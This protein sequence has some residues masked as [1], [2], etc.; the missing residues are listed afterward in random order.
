MSIKRKWLAHISSIL[1]TAYYLINAEQADEKVRLVRSVITVEHLRNSWNKTQT[2]PLL[3]LTTWLL[4]PR[5]MRYAPRE[6]RIPRP[7][8]SKYTE[9]VLG[10]LYYDGPISALK[11]QTKLILNIP[12]GGFVAMNPRTHDDSLMS[13]AAR[14]GMPVLSLDYRKAPEHPYPY[15]LHECFDVYRQLVLSRGRCAGLFT[16]EALQIIISG[17]SAGGNLAAGVTLMVLETTVPRRG[18]PR[19]PPP[20]DMLCEQLPS[21]VGLVLIYPCLDVNIGNWMTDEQM[22]LIKDRNAGHINRRVLRRKN[23]VYLR[24]ANT[25]YASDSESTPPDSTPSQSRTSSLEDLPKPQFTILRRPSSSVDTIARNG[26]RHFETPIAVPSMLSYFSD[27]VLTPEMMRAMIILYIGNRRKPDFSTDYYLSPV[28]APDEL[29]A[30]FPRTCFLT[31]ER[32]PLVDDTCV[33]AGRLRRAKRVEPGG[34]EGVTVKL[35]PGVSHGFMQLA[36]LY[37]K[38]WEYINL[39]SNW[40]DDLFR[41]SDRDRLNAVVSKISSPSTVIHRNESVSPPLLKEALERHEAAVSQGK[42]VGDIATDRVSKRRHHH[43]TATASS[44]SDSEPGLELK[45]KPLTSSLHG[46]GSARKPRLRPLDSPTKAGVKKNKFRRRS[47][48]SE[49]SQIKAADA[50]GDAANDAG[51]EEGNLNSP[52]ARSHPIRRGSAWDVRRKN[53]SSLAYIGESD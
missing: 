1:F 34:N 32:D 14:T 44:A 17:D 11:R 19:T 28:L 24:T 39:V 51:I 41:A 46:N 40:Y 36:A 33:M 38:A 43:R 10:W 13:W 9:P 31:G 29:L 25:P 8:G 21:P 18:L 50:P 23:S 4:R 26:P 5:T 16:G 2:N 49:V 3:K 22:S 53:R 37:P 47:T 7:H 42:L 12:G 45:M 27:R 15:A 35:I 48:D 52:L 20:H 6:I 30:K